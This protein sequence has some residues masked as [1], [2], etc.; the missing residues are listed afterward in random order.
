MA[1]ATV[2]LDDMCFNEFGRIDR[3]LGRLEEGIQSLTEIVEKQ[4]K[5]IEG[6]HNLVKEALEQVRKE[7]DHTARW[8]LVPPNG[9]EP[10]GRGESGNGSELP[11]DTNEE[12]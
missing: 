4:A 10:Q 7:E 6:I 12:F 1:N 8:G 11:F 9:E 3:Q 5:Y 2:R